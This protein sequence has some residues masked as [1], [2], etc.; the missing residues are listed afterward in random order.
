LFQADAAPQV[1]PAP[2][3]FSGDGQREK[4]KANEETSEA[5]LPP[6]PKKKIILKEKKKKKKSSSKAT[7]SVDPEQGV[8]MPPIT[9]V[10]DHPPTNAEATVAESLA[11]RQEKTSSC[12]HELGD[13]VRIFLL[14]NFIK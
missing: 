1:E 4:D 11:P 7:P 12:S 14:L 10:K 6:L 13:K 5:S 9:S 8:E 3:T 2:S